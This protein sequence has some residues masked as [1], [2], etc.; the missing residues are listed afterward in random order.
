MELL[1]I[2]EV[3]ERQNTGRINGNLSDFGAARAGIV[4]R[5]GL[6]ARLVLLAAGAFSPIQG[7]GDRHFKQAMILLTDPVIRQDVEISGSPT[8]IN[9]TLQ[10]WQELEADPR[11]VVIK[12]FRDKLTAHTAVRNSSIPLPKYG[13]MFSFSRE[14]ASLLEAFANATRTTS[15]KLSESDDFSLASAQAFWEPWEYMRP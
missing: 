4:V 1:Q 7:P 3:M 10:R 6:M 8:E 13:E 11:R 14:L 5:N 12:H 2:V 9:S 15:E